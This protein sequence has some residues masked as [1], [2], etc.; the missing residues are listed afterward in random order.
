MRVIGI[1]GTEPFLVQ[2]ERNLKEKS[3]G[4]HHGSKL[5]RG[6]AKIMI[7]TFPGKTSIDSCF[8]RPIGGVTIGSLPRNWGFGIYPESPIH[9]N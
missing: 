4:S 2:Y 8:K 1:F 6:Y 9:L 5:C 3:S 7:L